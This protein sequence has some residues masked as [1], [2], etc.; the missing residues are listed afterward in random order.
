MTA[1]MEAEILYLNPDDAIHGDQVLTANGFY[2][3][4]FNWKDPYGPTQWLKAQIDTELDANAFSA[5]IRRL[6]NPQGD[7]VSTY[8]I[9]TDLTT[10]QVDRTA[11]EVVQVIYSNDFGKEPYGIIVNPNT[12]T[13]EQLLDAVEGGS[14]V[15]LS[16]G[17][18]TVIDEIGIDGDDYTIVEE[19]HP[20]V[21]RPG[22]RNGDD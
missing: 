9:D 17:R 6:V 21:A 19:A 7:V 4:N 15:L 13:R 1:L 12:L 16:S 11:Q 10:A 14:V 20:Q 5:W 3:E 2:V 18:Y 8:N 22:D